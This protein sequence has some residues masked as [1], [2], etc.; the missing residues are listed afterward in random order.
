MTERKQECKFTL[1]SENSS[2]EFKAYQSLRGVRC[3]DKRPNIIV[4]DCYQSFDVV[5]LQKH[6]Q[7]LQTLVFAMEF[8]Q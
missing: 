5:E 8:K 2:F 6:I 4:V 7:Y 1:K 3:E